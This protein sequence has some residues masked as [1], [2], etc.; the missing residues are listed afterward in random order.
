MIAARTMQM[1]TDRLSWKPVLLSLWLSTA[2]AQ[3]TAPLSL[4]DWFAPEQQAGLQALVRQPVELAAL[5]QQQ[6]YRLLWQDSE[7]VQ[8]L[9]SMILASVDDGL[10][11]ED[12]HASRLR[13]LIHGQDTSHKVEQDLLLTDAYLLLAEHLL[14]GRLDPR[15]LDK[16]WQRSDENV[17]RS[18]HLLAALTA[19]N[20][21]QSLIDLYPQGLGYQQ[22]KDKQSLVRQWID[23]GAWPTVE[24][25]TKLKPGMRHPAVAQLRARLQVMDPLLLP[26]APELQETYDNELKK[27][28]KRFQAELGLLD[29]GIVGKSTFKALNI[30]AEQRLEQ[31]WSNL[32]RL[33]W[34]PRD[35]G[36][37]YIMA[38]IP[39]YQLKVVDQGQVA[40]TK[41]VIVGNPKRQT[42][43][44]SGRMTYMV[45]NPSWEVP[46]KLAAED[47][48]PLLKKDPYFLSENGF[49][50][51]YGWGE[52][53]TE[54]DPQSV[55]W[56]KY[57]KKYFPYRLRQN[58][59]PLN[60]LGQVKFMFPNKFDVYIHDTPSKNLFRAA[61][62]AFSSGCVRLEKPLELAEWLLSQQPRWTKQ[63]ISQRLS[64]PAQQSLAIN[65]MPVHL[66]YQTAWVDEQGQLQWR[67][68]IYQ[69][70]KRLYEANHAR[71]VVNLTP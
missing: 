62:R 64:D 59:G 25:K 32:E 34:L 45:V 22:L 53:Q 43:I 18:A 56:H 50:V 3:E 7:Q 60:A 33:R 61:Q 27:A 67:E 46:P 66:V 23:Q 54:I 30:T 6:E 26:V 41:K 38:N 20:I 55:D 9:L 5:Y 39:A 8:Q 51:F 11:P 15:K 13:E 2:A 14:Y 63:R 44:M 71:R 49:K 57:S 40:L 24:D 16:Q 52:N 47:K 69:A 21:R 65:P 17:D 4:L 29:D 28:V 10:L 31:I 36:G 12:Y 19:G 42:P 48:L 1:M 68:D 58:P 70:D 37:R 35:L